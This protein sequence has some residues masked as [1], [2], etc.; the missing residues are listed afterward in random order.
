VWDYLDRRHPEAAA[1]DLSVIALGDGWLVQ[2][3]GM[4][5]LRLLFMVNRYGFV[6]EMGRARVTAKTA[7][8]GSSVIS[9]TPL[10]IAPAEIDLTQPVRL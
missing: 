4:V 1:C 7:A 8:P 9:R 10:D 5:K 3:E 6:E 2:V